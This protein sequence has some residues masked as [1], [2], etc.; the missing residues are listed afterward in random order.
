MTRRT[1][2]A[3]SAF[4]PFLAAAQRAQR[5]KPALIELS[6]FRLRTGADNQ[7]QRATEFL[8]AYL[9]LL[10]RTGAGPSGAFVSSVGEGTP[11]VMMLR[12]YPDWAGVQEFK[13]KL[14]ADASI[15]AAIDKWYASGPP[16]V[17]YE[18]SLLRAFNSFPAVELPPGAGAAASRIFELRT[19]QSENYDTLQAKIDMFSKGEIGIFR[20]VGLRPVFFGETIFG[21]RMP[22]LTYMLAHDDMAAREKNWAAFRAHPEWKELQARPE[23]RHPGLVSNI[24]IALLSALPVSDIK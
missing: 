18:T 7:R 4:A 2:L 21:D 3:T 1:L 17:S 24:S 8:N 10:R 11:Y 19:Y 12:S 14:G 15:R 5:T 22:N 20:K 16:Y 13:A 9:P 6:Y 23:F